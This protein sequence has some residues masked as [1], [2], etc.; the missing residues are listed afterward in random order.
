MTQ[1]AE[2]VGQAAQG[3]ATEVEHFKG[4]GQAED[5]P[6]ELGQTTGQVQAGNAGQAPGF[7]IFKGMHRSGV[8]STI[9]GGYH[10]VLCPVATT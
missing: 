7:Q 5:F 2:V 8:Y 6:R 4:V 3:V 9:G 1:A 10:T